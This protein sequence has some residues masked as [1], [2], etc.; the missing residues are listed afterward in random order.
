MTKKLPFLSVLIFI[1]MAS[2]AQKGPFK[3]YRFTLDLNRVQNDRLKVELRTPPVDGTSITYHIPKIVPGMYSID[4]F[5]RYVEHFEAFDKN[6]HM[7]PV[8]RADVNSWKIA[9][10]N[11]LF[12]IVYQVNDTYDDRLT[13]QVVF[14]P[15]GSD[16]QK[17]TVFVINLHCFLGYFENMKD[18]PYQLTVIH[19]VKMYGSTALTD[20]NNSPTQ[21][22]FTAEN[23]NRIVDNPIMYNIPDT[24]VIAIGKSKVLVSVYS[25]NKIINSGFIAR[26]LS[27][28]LQAQTKYLGGKLPVDKYAFIIFL[29]DKPSL[30]GSEGALEHSYSSLYYMSERDSAQL[31]NDFVD[32]AAHEFFHIITPLSIHSDKIQYFNFAEPD[33]SEHLWLY[34]GST[35]Y[36]AHM[37][38]E[39]Y[40]LISPQELLNRLSEMITSS[41]TYYNDTVP[42]T[43]MSSEVVNTYKNQFQNVYEKGA[44]IAMCLDIKLLQLSGGKY[45]FVD[46]MKDLSL[47]YGKQKG[48]KDEELFG[49]IGKLTFPEIKKFLEQYVS[50]NQPLPLDQ[51]FQ[52]VGVNWIPV[53]ETKDSLFTIGGFKRHYNPDSK[54]YVVVDTAGMDAMGR[55]LGYHEGDEI[56]S[57]NGQDF[58]ALPERI[59]LADF[60]AS[61][62]KE[63][64]VKVARKNGEGIQDTIK[65]KAAQLKCPINKYNVLEFSQTATPDQ[66]KLRSVWLKPNGIQVN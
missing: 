43:R 17:D 66:F 61:A 33:M 18:I 9:H 19:P 10:A 23:Y 28:L 2:I 44:L 48:F 64:V 24:T 16:I 37:V 29:S 57:V 42:F 46:M 4:D 49:E 50:G 34:E 15:G 39:K 21:D 35:E 38:Q 56:I 25:P 7:L 62:G 11:K 31:G 40:G 45:G 30:S 54:R 22:R 47:R 27:S 26:K 55:A 58:V 60:Q 8:K 20:E 3:G 32:D 13:D 14:E 36:H 65:L 6:G 12:K 59:F 63:L 1:A 53:L 51:V 52:S 41:R 5:G